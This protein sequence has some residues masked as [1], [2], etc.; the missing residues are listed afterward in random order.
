MS[1]MV[2]I[3]TVNVP[4]GG[5]ASIQFTNI[6]QTYTDLV[7]RYS[8]R[9]TKAS[10][11]C[12]ILINNS[13]ANFTLREFYGS[14]SSYFSQGASSNSFQSMATDG[15]NFTANTFSNGEIY[16]PNYTSNRNK[17][18]L[19]NT[20]LENNATT[21]YAGFS[22]GLWSNTAAI[23]SFTLTAALSEGTFA[24]HSTA[25]LYGVYNTVLGLGAKATGEGSVYEDSNY[26]YHV[27]TSSGT[28]T[29]TQ[30]LTNVDYLVVAG[31]GAGGYS[32]GAGGGAGGLRCTVG[33][34][35]GGGSLENKVSFSNGISYTVTVGGGGAGIGGNG[36]GTSGSN[37]SISGSGFTSITSTG[38]GGGGGNGQD[39]GAS[40]GS[41]GGG[42]GIYGS[43]IGGSGTANQGYAGGNNNS[44]GSSGGGGG[45]AGAVGQNSSAGGGVGGNGVQI[46]ALATV[47]GTGANNGYYA[48]G[49]NGFNTGGTTPGGLGGGATDGANG[50]AYTGG[51]GG[52]W[53]GVSTSGSGGSGIVIIRYAK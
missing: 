18:F 4:A 5:Q 42:G 19:I 20:T 53:R 22:S 51:G 35:G 45:G 26:F 37:S 1:N 21:S 38:G 50:T 30:N 14:G 31:G 8:L 49:G 27:Y 6:P 39:N 48:G 36:R 23:T 41:G 52:A 47:T 13:S 11:A 17:S 2:A 43:G 25:T 3:E 34:T 9:N 15:V 40:G 29:P 28:F 10:G 24:Q 32:G 12:F 33:A 7:I 44:G 16:I 46:T